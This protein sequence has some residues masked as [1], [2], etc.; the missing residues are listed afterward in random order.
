MLLSDALVAL[1]RWILAAGATL[2]HRVLPT[3]TDDNIAA[4][5]P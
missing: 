3:R 5:M 1:E 4:A 2:E